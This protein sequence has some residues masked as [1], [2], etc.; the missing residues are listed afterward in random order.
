MLP[1]SGCVWKACKPRYRYSPGRF[2]IL[3]GAAV[4]SNKHKHKML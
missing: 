4:A 2:Y 1:M 3:P